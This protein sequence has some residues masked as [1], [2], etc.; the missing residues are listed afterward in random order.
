MYRTNQSLQIS[1]IGKSRHASFPLF[2]STCTCRYQ[3]NFRKINCFHNSLHKWLFIPC[4]KKYKRYN[5]QYTLVVY[6]LPSRI[7][8]SQTTIFVLDLN[9]PFPKTFVFMIQVLSLVSE[10]EHTGLKNA[11]PTEKITLIYFNAKKGF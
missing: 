11:V 4:T 2:Y 10:I 3:I 7:P 8:L 1:K 9:V 6:C 5:L